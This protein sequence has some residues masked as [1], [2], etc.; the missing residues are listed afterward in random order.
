M[1]GNSTAPN[2]RERIRAALATRDDVARLDALR[3]L[4]DAAPGY[5]ETIQIDKALAG[6]A[7]QAVD[8]QLTRLRVAVLSS[9]TVNHLVPGLRVAALRRG[10]FFDV[11]AGAFAQYRQELLDAATPLESFKPDVV[12]LSLSARPLIGVI[13]IDADREHVEQLLKSEIAAVRGLWE[14][15]RTRFGAVVLQQTYLDVFEPIFG[16]YDRIAPASPARVIDRLNDLLARSAGDD[17]VA[18]VDAARACARDGIDAWFDAARW[19]QGKMEIAPQAGG[20]YGELVARVV[21]A[22]RG[23]SRKCAGARSRQHAVGRR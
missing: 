10:L 12:V 11:F 14:M 8:S 22:Q 15:A 19:L 20:R 5:V 18:L 6:I 16:S 1:S 4:S 17:N 2:F 21:A 13:P 23:R 3:T 9:A 7:A